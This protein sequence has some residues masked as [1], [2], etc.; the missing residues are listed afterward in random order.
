MP[1]LTHE[2][3]LCFRGLPEGPQRY[4]PAEW[5]PAGILSFRT[6]PA[7]ASNTGNYTTN[8]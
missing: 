7:V 2:P 1:F 4:F 3:G 5:L 8:F 6:F